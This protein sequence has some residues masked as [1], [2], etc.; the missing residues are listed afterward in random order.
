MWLPTTCETEMLCCR[1]SAKL[2][3]YIQQYVSVVLYMPAETRKEAVRPRVYIDLWWKFMVEISNIISILTWNDESGKGKEMT[4]QV[5]RQEYNQMSV[6]FQRTKNSIIFSSQDWLEWNK[7]LCIR[8]SLKQRTRKIKS[9][10]D[11]QRKKTKIES[12]SSEK[13]LY[14]RLSRIQVSIVF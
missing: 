2:P 4:A 14:F 10:T 12:L 3:K 13:W 5:V 9:Q 6:K 11:K 1:Q 7:N 8:K